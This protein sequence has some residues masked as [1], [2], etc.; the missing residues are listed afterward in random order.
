MQQQQQGWEGEQR[1][2]GA[3]QSPRLTEQDRRPQPQAAPA[4]WKLSA[5]ASSGNENFLET[6]GR[7][8]L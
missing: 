2:P 5:K 4:A 6:G 1:L 7:R 8:P 3:T